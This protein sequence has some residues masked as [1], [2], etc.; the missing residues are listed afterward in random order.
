V[1]PTRFKVTLLLFLLLS[2]SVLYTDAGFD[3]T[4]EPEAGFQ[5]SVPDGRSD[6]TYGNYPFCAVGLAPS[7]STDT[8]KLL[9]FTF[10]VPLNALQYTGG[11][12]EM[13]IAP[14]IALVKNHATHISEAGLSGAYY[15]L[16]ASND[17]TV[18][19]KFFEYSFWC[20]RENV[21][22]LSPT[23]MYA[24]FLL[25]DVFTNRVDFKNRL[26]LK[27][28]GAVSA[29]LHALAKAGCSWNISNA[30]GAGYVQ[31]H[32][33]GGITVA[34]DEKN[35]LLF[36]LSVAY[37]FYQSTNNRVMD[38]FKRGRSGK[39]TDT[40]ITYELSQP[41]IP[42]ANLYCGYDREVTAHLN[43]HGYYMA[44][45]FGR[46]APHSLI[47]SHQT[48]VICSWHRK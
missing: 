27:V 36:Q 6:S 8:A 44:V 33:T 12:G 39:K 25:S 4:V 19:V 16:P 48:G 18:P 17:P 21:G 28:S 2:G 10:T 38:I 14:Q 41:R 9:S 5:S 31:P 42:F 13:D 32:V 45:L 15:M 37:S 40:L 7:W 46:G 23:G 3:V 30:K 47:V 35:L 22:K 1:Q 20:Q 34:V 29:R 43:I 24:F 11:P 26:Q